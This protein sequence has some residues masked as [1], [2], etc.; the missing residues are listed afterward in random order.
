MHVMKLSAIALAV[1][2]GASQLAMAN[3]QSEARGLM[4]D[5]TFDLFNRNLYFNRDF[6]NG[7]GQ[8][9]QE[10]WAHG[11]T[12]TFKSGFT[13]GTVGFGFDAYGMV[14]LKLDS[15]PSR[16]GTGLLPVGSDGRAEDEYSEAGGAIKARMS[17]SVLKYGQQIVGVPVFATDD[18]RLLP[19]TATGFLLTSSEIEGLEINAGHFTALNAQAQTGHDSYGAGLTRANFVGG[20]YSVDDNFSL[21][22]YYS[23][24]D[25]YWDKIYANLN[26]SL[27]LANEQALNFDFNIYRTDYDATY[28]GTGDDEGNTIWSLAATYS[29]GAHSF[30]LAYQKSIGGFDGI[31][32]DYGV[33]GGGT[34]YLANSVQ[35]SDFNAQDEKSWQARYDLDLAAVGLNGFKFMTRY[36][37]GDDA[38]VGTTDNG[39]EWERDIELRYVVPEGPAKDLS[40]RLRQA[41]YRSSDGVYYGSRSIDEVRVIIEYPLSIL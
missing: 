23:E 11:F 31:G 34:V 6:Q 25:D 7:T 2:A 22:L 35:R 13:P 17:S 26:Y 3:A 39:K 24:V 14:G 27:A 15:S 38:D 10:E 29:L 28:T 16:A 18:S 8:S 37:Y 30:M 9:K 36:I 41:T 40:L 20:T 1:T 21:S 12:A 5:S 4:E 32:Y 19:E 33:D